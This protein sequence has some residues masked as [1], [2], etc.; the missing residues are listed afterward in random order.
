M[1]AGSSAS[2]YARATLSRALT[3]VSSY[4][5]QGI[6]FGRKLGVAVRFF[7]GQRPT[8][9]LIRM[10][11]GGNA[12]V[13]A[14]SDANALSSVGFGWESRNNGGTQEFRLFAH[15]GATYSA[16]SAWQSLGWVSDSLYNAAYIAV[17]SDGAGT[18]TGFYGN[19]GNRNLS[20]IT[21]SGG[22]TTPGN[23]TNS[24][25]DF[26]LVNNSAGSGVGYSATLIDSML[27]VRS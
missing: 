17:Y 7:V 22:P 8:D 20:T 16:N 5:G 10:V 9:H 14:T 25:V 11:V 24:Y 2:G 26:L 12:G 23:A 21:L 27:I 19:N 1:N 4:S 6:A 15:N 13:P 18:I 3:T